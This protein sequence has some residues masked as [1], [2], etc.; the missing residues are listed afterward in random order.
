MQSRLLYVAIL[1]QSCLSPSRAEPLGGAARASE[2]A[3]PG[4]VQ[5]SPAR[6]RAVHGLLAAAAAR[7]RGLPADL[8]RPS[9]QWSPSAP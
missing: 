6:G 3:L 1:A 8:E 5:A 4:G 7:V 2:P 9:P